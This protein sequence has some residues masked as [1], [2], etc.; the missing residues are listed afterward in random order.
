MLMKI[1]P[2]DNLALLIHD[3]HRL[4][5]REFEARAAEYGLSSSQWRLLF[6]LSKEEGATQAKLAEF[7]EIEPIS[8]S[9]LL[10]RMEQAGWIERR[11]DPTDRRVRLIHPTD[12]ARDAFDPIRTMT[13]GII[14]DALAG[15]THE[16]RQATTDGLRRIIANLTDAGA[17][18]QSC[19][20]EAA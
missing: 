15:L 16:Q 20:N 11:Q 10:D 4:L 7:L 8:V 9:R 3:A 17:S 18:L 6:R 13:L 14:D 12:K 19:K 1:L 5:R 2:Q